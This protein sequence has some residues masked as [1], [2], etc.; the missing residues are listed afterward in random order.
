MEAHIRKE[1]KATTLEQ[2]FKRVAII[3][4]LDRSSWMKEK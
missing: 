2:F 1:R 4:L 3:D